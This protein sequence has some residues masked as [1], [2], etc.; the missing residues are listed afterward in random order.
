MI[1]TLLPA[2]ADFHALHQLD[3]ERYPFLLQST[4]SGASLGSHDLLLIAS[5]IRRKSS[6]PET[7]Q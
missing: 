5:G 3:P 2:G 7:N 4:A 6:A 1:S